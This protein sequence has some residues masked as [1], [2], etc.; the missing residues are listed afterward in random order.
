MHDCWFG[1][2]VERCILLYI[3]LYVFFLLKIFLALVLVCTASLSM[4]QWCWGE[5]LLGWRVLFPMAFTLGGRNE[6]VHAIFG[7]MSFVL[8]GLFSLALR[9]SLSIL[10]YPLPEVNPGV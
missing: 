7:K 10:I 8:G 2:S 5:G 3:V 1:V 6:W 9:F 4:S